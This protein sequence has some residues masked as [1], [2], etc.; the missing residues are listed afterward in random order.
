MKK[1]TSEQLGEAVK[2][3]IETYK[4]VRKNPE[5]IDFY[6]DHP[7]AI[8]VESVAENNLDNNFYHIPD[9]SY[10]A[11]D[12]AD[13]IRISKTIMNFCPICDTQHEKL[14]ALSRKDN[15]TMICEAC[16]TKEAVADL[17]DLM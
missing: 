13:V 1:L 4:E 15:K 16:G 2:M 6:K 9:F 3:T 11:K 10:T 5:Y 17:L 12:L 8:T 14:L 7:A